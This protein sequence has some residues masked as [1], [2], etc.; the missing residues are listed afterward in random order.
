MFPPNSF[1]DLVKIVNLAEKLYNIHDGKLLIK[2]I[3]VANLFYL[4]LRVF[5]LLIPN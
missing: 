1:K 4:K 2:L 5:L 3:F